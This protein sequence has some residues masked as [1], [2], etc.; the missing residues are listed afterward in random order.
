MPD[1]PAEMQVKVSTV[2]T[3]WRWAVVDFLIMF[4]GVFL[5]IQ[6]AKVI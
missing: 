4:L 3:G 1:M 2:S 5:A 6:A